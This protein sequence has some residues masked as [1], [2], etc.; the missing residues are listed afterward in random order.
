MITVTY[1]LLNIGGHQH[2]HGSDS[3]APIK[4]TKSYE[5]HEKNKYVKF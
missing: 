3:G 1:V 2:T 5:M 4:D